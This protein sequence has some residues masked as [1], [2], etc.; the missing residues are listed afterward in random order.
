MRQRD[1]MINRRKK[2]LKH[3][4]WLEKYCHHKSCKE[5]S[6]DCPAQHLHCS[7]LLGLDTAIAWNLS[8]IIEQFIYGNEIPEFLPGYDLTF[9]RLFIDNTMKALSLHLSHSSARSSRYN[10]IHE[11]MIKMDKIYSCIT[12]IIQQENTTHRLKR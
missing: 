8:G 1:I 2:L 7:E 9:V 4:K 5:P 6:Y 10:R 12:Y 3:V 11:L